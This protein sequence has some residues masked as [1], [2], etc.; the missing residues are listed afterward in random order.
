[1]QASFNQLMLGA[2][3]YIRGIALANDDT[4][5]ETEKLNRW[6]KDHEP[7]ID[8]KHIR[9]ADVLAKHLLEANSLS[10]KL[11]VGERYIPDFDPI[12]SSS[13]LDELEELVCWNCS[14]QGIP[15]KGR[16]LRRAGFISD[17]DD[18]YPGEGPIF[19]C[20]SQL[21]DVVFAGQDLSGASGHRTAFRNVL[22]HDCR[23]QHLRFSEYSLD[24]SLQISYSPHLRGRVDNSLFLVTTEEDEQSNNSKLSSHHFSNAI[25]MSCIFSNLSNLQLNSVEFD[26]CEF[27][28]C[29][30]VK[31]VYGPERME[32][33]SR[34]GTIRGVSFTGWKQGS[35]ILE[36]LGVI[37]NSSL[38]VMKSELEQLRVSCDESTNVRHKL[39]LHGTEVERL[40]LNRCHITQ[41]KG[42]NLAKN[43]EPNGHEI[44]D[45]DIE[46]SEFVF[47]F[48]DEVHLVLKDCVIK[49]ADPEKHLEI[50][51]VDFSNSR[52]FNTTFERCQIEGCKFPLIPQTA[53]EDEFGIR[54]V[55]CVFPTASGD[56]LGY[57][58][59]RCTFNSD[60]RNE[61][62]P[63]SLHWERSRFMDSTFHQSRGSLSFKED[64]FLQ[65]CRFLGRPGNHAWDLMF[66]QCELRSCEYENVTWDHHVTAFEECD[67]VEGTT[68]C[69]FH[70]LSF[71]KCQIGQEY[72]A[73][74]RCQRVVFADFMEKSTGAK[75]IAPTLEIH[76][77]GFCSAKFC[78]PDKPSPSK[79]RVHL[80]SVNLDAASAAGIVQS[81]EEM[82][83]SGRAHWKGSSELASL[84]NRDKQIPRTSYGR[85]CQEPVNELK[86]LLEEH[87]FHELLHCDTLLHIS[88]AAVKETKIA[89]W[90]NILEEIEKLDSRMERILTERSMNVYRGSLKR[91]KERFISIQNSQ[92]T[93]TKGENIGMALKSVRSF[94][95]LLRIRT[96]PD[97]EGGECW[98]LSKWLKELCIQTHESIK[99]SEKI[100]L[101][102]GELFDLLQII[103]NNVYMHVSEEAC[104]IAYI[105]ECCKNGTIILDIKDNGPGFGQRKNIGEWK[106]SKHDRFMSFCRRWC[107]SAFLYTVIESEKIAVRVDLMSNTEDEDVPSSSPEWREGVGTAFRFELKLPEPQNPSPLGSKAE[108]I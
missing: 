32:F 13:E 70:H 44:N 3:Y 88:P 100:C 101:D 48:F 42:S 66:Q 31:G 56:L 38:T 98:G 64:C 57:I 18:R 23:L 55:D 12:S 19:L 9:V 97:V 50:K 10:H 83:F 39:E 4:S 28:D 46:L 93:N 99:S 108:R 67:V 75:T 81:N 5:E 49:P 8:L 106:N 105:N 95:R 51:G 43:H 37:S 20:G 30:I 41:L 54:F 63:Y 33:R 25:F 16:T 15:F 68:F 1:M 34:G 76:R 78:I 86:E 90:L 71:E 24:G 62:S 27:R 103:C 104:P 102:F 82:D 35:I 94:Q 74:V 22:F 29:R 59:D 61:L 52:F 79:L 7:S 84:L 11:L 6:I 45:C 72:Q 2:L 21:E 92:D 26:D 69:G 53:T 14:I 96:R 73:G 107:R 60:F 58:F 80:D 36:D 77:S 87:C 91:L 17:R 89:E 40:Q 85:Q 47:G 65:Q